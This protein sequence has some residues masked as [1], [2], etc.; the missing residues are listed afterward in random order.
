MVANMDNMPKPE[1]L[2]DAIAAVIR[3]RMRSQGLSENMLATD[4]GIPRVTLRNRFVAP[5]R[6]SIRELRL[7]ADRLGT[8]AQEITAAAQK[9]TA[10]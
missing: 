8:T 6:L 1:P 10:A 5:G 7:I 3:E 2:E 4:T 9:T